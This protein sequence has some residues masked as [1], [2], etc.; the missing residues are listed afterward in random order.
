MQIL[1]HLLSISLPRSTGRLALFFNSTTS[2]DGSGGSFN[3]DSY[4]AQKALAVLSPNLKCGW[5][6]LNFPNAFVGQYTDVYFPIRKRSLSVKELKLRLP[7][8]HNNVTLTFLLS[9]SPSETSTQIVQTSAW[10]K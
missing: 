5:V 10:S 8:T 4:L 2:V 6:F 9:I 1:L 3:A 7:F